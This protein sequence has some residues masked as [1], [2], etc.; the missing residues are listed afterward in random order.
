MRY[1]LKSAQT[2]YPVS[3]A[4]LA[5]LLR[6]DDYTDP[7]LKFMLHSATDAAIAHT[8]RSF[9]TQEHTIQWD[10]VPG[11][12][13]RDVALRPVRFIEDTWIELPYA[14]LIQVKTVKTIDL[15][16]NEQTIATSNYAVDTISQPGRIRFLNG[17]PAV[18]D[19]TRLQV[20]Y[21]SG[22][23]ANPEQVPFA[24]RHGI[25]MA[26]AYLYEH[27]GECDAGSAIYKSGADKV[28]N[29]YRIVY[30]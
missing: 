21:D 29:P 27:R 16:N 28:L 3:E 13:P 10:G 7:N 4:E 30:L 5:D 22:Y 9:L 20:V 14:P 17:Y 12:G 19:G 26:A 11:N 23:G 25:L 1:G 24:I 6:L 18:T 8:S 15:Q 2:T